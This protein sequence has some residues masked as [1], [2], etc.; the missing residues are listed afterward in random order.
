MFNV[1]EFEKRVRHEADILNQTLKDERIHEHQRS[2]AIYLLNITEFREKWRIS[3]E[4]QDQSGSLYQEGNFE[5][6]TF[7]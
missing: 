4:L 1:Y 7:I 3:K 6:G 2:K 5:N